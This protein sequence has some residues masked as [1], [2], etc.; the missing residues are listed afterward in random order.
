MRHAFAAGIA[1]L[2]FG[3]SAVSHAQQAIELRD[4]LRLA[5]QNEIL[6]AVEL[7]HRVWIVRPDG[8]L[9][10]YNAENGN[11]IAQSPNENYFHILRGTEGQLW[12]LR[13][14]ERPTQN[15]GRTVTSARQHDA[16]VLEYPPITLTAQSGLSALVLTNYGPLIV[17]QTQIL[18]LDDRS[19]RATPLT[20]ELAGGFSRANSLL[21]DGRTLYLGFNNGEWG[22]GMQRIDLTTGAVDRVDRRETGSL[23]ADPLNSACDPVTGV[24]LT[25]LIRDV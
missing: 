18:R 21:A 16:E 5:M 20:H 7:G 25:N 13:W 19:W 22:G 11:L 8:Q 12:T 4:A 23:C 15:S 14:R 10:T 6:E 17:T 24:I 1:A 2:V 3:M 9:Q